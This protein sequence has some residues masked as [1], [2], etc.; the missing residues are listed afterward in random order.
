MGEQRMRGRRT[1]SRPN[2]EKYYPEKNKRAVVR[3]KWAD[4][5]KK[6]RRVKGVCKLQ[7][8]QKKK[9][10]PRAKGAE[11]CQRVL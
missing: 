9:R 7:E 6:K 10:V 2:N 8:R 3:G 5:N 1:Q 11:A 4:Q